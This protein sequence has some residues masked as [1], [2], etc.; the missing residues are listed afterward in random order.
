MVIGAWGGARLAISGRMFRWE[1]SKPEAT[2]RVEVRECFCDRG[3]MDAIMSEYF[4][5]T[6]DSMSIAYRSSMLQ[7]H[8]IRR[9]RWLVV[10]FVSDSLSQLTDRERKSRSMRLVAKLSRI[11]ARFWVWPNR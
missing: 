4:S 10:F 2:V 5:I 8:L 3:R 11:A 9:D 1:K 7:T 6:I